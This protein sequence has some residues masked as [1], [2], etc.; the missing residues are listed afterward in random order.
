MKDQNGNESRAATKF[1]L[2][3][4]IPFSYPIKWNGE[5]RIFSF[6]YAIEVGVPRRDFLENFAE[7]VA[8]KKKNKTT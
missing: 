5:K 7:L 3:S 2:I 8:E 4:T 6:L 1:N